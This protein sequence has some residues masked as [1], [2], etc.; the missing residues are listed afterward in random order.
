MSEKIGV[1]WSI[2]PHTQAKHEILRYY[3]GAWFPI[4]VTTQHRLLY[5][6]GF[7]GPGE[8]KGRED[9]SPIIALKVAK[10]HKLSDKLQR[11]GTELVFFFIELDE[12]R[13]QNLERKLAELQLPSNFRVG[14]YCDSFENA[15]GNALAEIEEQS[16][17]LAPSFVFI[18]PGANSSP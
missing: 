11:P 13:F 1:T 5:I 6:D 2:P 4:L 12:A 14:K 16:K 17:H 10:D 3:L 7:V 18:D 9:G 8:H 15:F